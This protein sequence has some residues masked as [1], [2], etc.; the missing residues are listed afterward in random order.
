MCENGLLHLANMDFAI[1]NIAIWGLK[2]EEHK[3]IRHSNR[4]TDFVVP[5]LKSKTL[6]LWHHT[7]LIYSNIYSFRFLVLGQ[8][9]RAS[10]SFHQIV[11][12]SNLKTLVV[13]H[14]MDQIVSK[15]ANETERCF[16]FIQVSKVI[17]IEVCREAHLFFCPYRATEKL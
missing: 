2:T 8:A 17:A 7:Y 12:E 4:L 14:L 10:P 16:S 15:L 1:C 11:G 9:E 5:R 13:N 3:Y 6:S